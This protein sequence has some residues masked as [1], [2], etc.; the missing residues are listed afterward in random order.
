M[1]ENFAGCYTCDSSSVAYRDRPLQ[2]GPGKA[3]LQIAVI[4]KGTTHV[5]W[6]SVH[7]GAVDAGKET[8][9]EIIWNG[10]EREDREKEIQIVEDLSLQKVSGI[11]L[12]PNDDNALVPSVEKVAA[13]G[14]LCVIID[15][16]VQT[17]KYLSFVAT[18]NYQGGVLAAKRMGEILAGKGK[19]IVLKF[20]PARPPRSPGSMVLWIRLKKIFREF[21]LWIPNSDLIQWRPP[22]R[23]RRI[24]LPET[25]RLTGFLR[26][27]NRPPWGRWGIAKFGKG[28][29]NKNGRL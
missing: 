18:D 19:I 5:F 29:Q 11:V 1:K 12:A 8:G 9:A 4:P 23:Q 20:A 7:R 14:I 26:V 6:Q 22:C 21:R 10:P 27:T 15:S 13:A 3:K 16:S 25:P 2:Q 24:C 17:D 28:P